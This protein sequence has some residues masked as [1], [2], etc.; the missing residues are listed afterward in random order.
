[1]GQVL[2]LETD[3]LERYQVSRAVFR[4]AVRL[5]E[6]REVA[7][8]RRGPGGGL[9][10]T[11]PTVEAVIDAVVFY[12]HRVDARLDEVFEARMVLEEIACDLASR[13]LEEADLI[14]MRSFVDKDSAGR[15]RDHRALHNLLARGT[16]NPAIELFVDVLNR[17]VS[18][19]SAGWNVE[20]AKGESAT[21]HARIAEAVIAGD[22]A[23][24][25]RRMRKHLQAESDYI[26]RRRT[27]HQ[28]LPI[29]MLTEH[30]PRGKMAEGVARRLVGDVLTRNLQPGQLIGTE[31]ELIGREAVSRAVF[32]EAVRIL[33]HHQIANMR[34]GPGGG[35]FVAEPSVGA[36]SDVT[37][38]LL[39]RRGM[40]LE[41]LSDLRTDLETA[42]VDLAVKRLDAAGRTRIL[43]ALEREASGTERERARVVYDLHAAIAAAASNR[44]LELVALVLIRLSRLYQ[45]ER[46]APRDVHRIQAEIHRTHAA[47]AEAVIGGDQALARHR[48]NRHLIALGTIVR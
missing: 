39:A 30:G 8:T 22:S 13:R 14:L 19:Y 10:I 29:S 28:A 5:L 38:I 44:V 4:E 45:I 48:M 42:I 43:D 34:R 6:N 32:R 37:A 31:T 41:Q 9:V 17:V 1:V 16:Q 20:D 15:V 24:A 47:I 3:L 18:L 7:R 26:R 35:L 40:R 46:L 21:A 23:T 25:R 11:E 12:L 2:G 33:E 36:V 27:T